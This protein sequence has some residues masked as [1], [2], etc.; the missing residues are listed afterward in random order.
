MNI[1]QLKTGGMA[2]IASALMLSG[3][4]SAATVGAGS[5]NLGGTAVGNTGG[6]S[7]YYTTPGDMTSVIEQPTTG[8]FASLTSGTPE[9]VMPLTTANGVTP[10]MTFD[11]VDFVTLTDGI[12]LDATSLPIP[13]GLSACPTSGTIANNTSCLVN[14]MSPVVLTQTATGVSASL[15]LYGQ[16]HYAGQTDYTPF[17][18]LFNAPST[19]FATVSDFQDYF[20]THSGNI[21][22]V[23]Y[24][25][26]FTTMPT[27]STPEPGT[28]AVVALGLIG[29]GFY[30]RSKK[31]VA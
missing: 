9:A 31:P 26:S 3:S 18:G 2:L 14:A 13:S 5:F 6:V 21:P 20:D 16:A 10:G 8:V 7:F 11:L 1:L 15:T 29:C 12:D 4:A 17:I 22:P 23:S 30:R 28:L 25:A 24:A 19:N 27:S